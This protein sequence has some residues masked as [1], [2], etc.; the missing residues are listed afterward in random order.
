MGA[1]VFPV[2]AFVPVLMMIAA[3]FGQDADGLLAL[4]DRVPV[5]GWTAV[6]L[7]SLS[8]LFQALHKLTRRKHSTATS[9][10]E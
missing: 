1:K 7:A 8:G 3:A 10:P 5:Y 4:A 9:L 2:L 6:G